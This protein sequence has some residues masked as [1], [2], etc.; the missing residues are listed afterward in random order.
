MIPRL[1]DELVNGDPQARMVRASERGPSFV[2]W[3]TGALALLQLTS[4]PERDRKA[5][6]EKSEEQVG[7]TGFSAPGSSARSWPP[8]APLPT[9]GGDYASH[10]AFLA[11]WSGSVLL[12]EG[13]AMGTSGRPGDATGVFSGPFLFLAAAGGHQDVFRPVPMTHGVE[14]VGVRGLRSPRS[15]DVFL[16]DTGIAKSEAPGSLYFLVPHLAQWPAFHVCPPPCSLFFPSPGRLIL[17]TPSEA[18]R[19]VPVKLNAVNTKANVVCEQMFLLQL[20]SDFMGST[21]QL[22]PGA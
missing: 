1:I 7:A 12:V 15:L 4:R 8:V 21:E 9:C 16:L 18:R 2:L 20:R 6:M 14:R 10:S 3:P 11:C 13:Q 19:L 22:Q 17:I 5:T